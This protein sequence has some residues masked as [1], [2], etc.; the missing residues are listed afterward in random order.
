MGNFVLCL[1][2]QPFVALQ[3]IA[4]MHVVMAVASFIVLLVQ[5]G[6]SQDPVLTN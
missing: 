4:A 5:G 2:V 6:W 1:V 3:P